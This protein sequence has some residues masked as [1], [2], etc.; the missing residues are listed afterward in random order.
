MAKRPKDKKPPFEVNDVVKIKTSQGYLPTELTKSE[1]TRPY[2]FIVRKVT[3][4]GYKH[5]QTGWLVDVSDGQ[6][7]CKLKK[8][9]ADWFRKV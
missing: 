8:Y 4:V 3:Y 9:D 1:L 7:I 6:E 2:I 5:S